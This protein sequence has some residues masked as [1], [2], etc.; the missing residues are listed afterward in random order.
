VIADV[1]ADRVIVDATSFMHEQSETLAE[2]DH[3]LKEKA[4]ERGLEFFRVPIPYDAPQFIDMLADLCVPFLEANV[5]S[6]MSWQ[7]CNCQAGAHC[8]NAGIRA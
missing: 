3:E 6:R 8:L 1:D 5:A 4:E 7:E 2:L